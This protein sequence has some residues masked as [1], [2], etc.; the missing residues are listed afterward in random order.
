MRHF[1]PD[2][3]WRAYEEVLAYE[4]RLPAGVE[5]IHKVRSS[6]RRLRY[7]LEIFAGALPSAAEDFVEELSSLQDTLGELH[8]HAVA[9]DRIDAWVMRGKFRLTG[10]LEAYR[11][12]HV[13]ERDR[14]RAGFE[15]AW[16]ALS[17][18]RFRFALSRLVSGEIRASRPDGA[19]KLTA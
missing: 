18:D 2:E 11:A 4:T 19:I 7:A 12:H 1:L 9:V 14:L 3:A 5:V 16:R 13:A 10:A 6:C 15:P 17:G 8:D